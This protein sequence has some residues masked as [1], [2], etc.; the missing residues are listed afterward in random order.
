MKDFLRSTKSSGRDSLR[1]LDLVF[2]LSTVLIVMTV[3]PL[4]FGLWLD[5]SYGTAP[6]GTLCLIFLGV[7]GGMIAMF[8][9]IKDAYNRIGGKKNEQS[10]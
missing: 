4:L 9:M 8:R 1:G 5:R 7:A 2:Q 6:F 3:G 10:K